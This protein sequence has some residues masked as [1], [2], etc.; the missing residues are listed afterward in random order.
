M[1]K[2]EEEE[3]DY[4]TGDGIHDDDWVRLFEILYSAFMPL[5]LLPRRSKWKRI[6]K[7]IASREMQSKRKRTN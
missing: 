4:P 2:I 5:P 7:T 1:M 3:E 6:P